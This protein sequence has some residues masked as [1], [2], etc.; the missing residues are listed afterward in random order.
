MAEPDRHRLPIP[1][2]F[3]TPSADRPFDDGDLE[4]VIGR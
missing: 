4:G 1:D 2:W 3:S